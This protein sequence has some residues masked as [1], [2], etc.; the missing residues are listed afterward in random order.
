MK[1][2]LGKDRKKENMPTTQEAV[3]FIL[4]LIKGY[5]PTQVTI[6]IDALDEID[7]DSEATLSACL[8]SLLNE[9]KGLVKIFVSSRRENWIRYWLD[10]CQTIEVTQTKTRLDLELYIETGVKR[11]GATVFDEKL[12][13]E[14][15]VQLKDRARGE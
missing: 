9:S 6:I 1:L 8:D 7:R 14:V 10:G 12:K 13:N 15:K 5:Y 3:E 11:R 4:K 2:A